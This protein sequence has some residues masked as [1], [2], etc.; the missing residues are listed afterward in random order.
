MKTREER[1][2]ELTAIGRKL[3]LNKMI[4]GSDGNLS[5]RLE[6]GNILV[7]A[8]GSRLG[9][10]TESDFVE[11]DSDGNQINGN[12][13]PTS[14][15]KMH[16]FVYKNRPEINY[17]VHSHPVNATAFAVAGEELPENILPEVLVFVGRIPLTEYAPPGT[18]SVPESISP[19]IKNSDAFLLRNHGLLT[20]GKSANEAM[21]RHETVEHFARIIIKAR[22][23]GDLTTIP[24]EDV[25][26]LYAL[27]EKM[28][29]E[30][31]LS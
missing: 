16:L 24:K 19:F 29:T 13:L 1:V 20:I 7:T 5:A 22:Q 21:N 25:S 9:E 28:N 23:L 17:S 18:D 15:L 10:L 14:E 11:I 8:S 2:R 27:R 31:Q 12:G 6:N 3:L 26:R 4:A 30:N